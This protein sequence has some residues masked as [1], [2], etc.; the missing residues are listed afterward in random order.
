MLDHYRGG[1]TA[2][3]VSTVG[4]NRSL[5]DDLAKRKLIYLF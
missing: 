2:A 1:A 5:S 3:I 4:A